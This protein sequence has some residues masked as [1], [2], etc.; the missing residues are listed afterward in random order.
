MDRSRWTIATIFIV[1]FAMG[2]SAIVYHH[3]SCDEIL[4]HWDGA[5][6][7]LIRRADQVELW[8]VRLRV[9][10]SI[11]SSGAT[12]D[13]FVTD[14]DMNQRP[15]PFPSDWGLDLVEGR[16]ANTAAGIVN[17]R[18]ALVQ[19]MTY[20]WSKPVEPA[21]AKAAPWDFALW[22]LDG[23]Q[24]TLVLFDSKQ[25]KVWQTK[26]DVILQLNPQKRGGYE[27]YFRELFESK[28]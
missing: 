2:V 18:H 16:D 22:F 19:D 4:K 7:N 1:A 14:T 12:E 15:S 24:Q 28:K 9:D 6:G 13:A 25:G 27:Q 20:D 11:P 10:D 17:A 21:S 5:D 26:S 23:D 3:Y 8:R